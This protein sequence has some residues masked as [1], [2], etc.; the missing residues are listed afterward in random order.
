MQRRQM[1]RQIAEHRVPAQQAPHP[2][3]RLIFWVV[4]DEARVPATLPVGRSRPIEGIAD[5]GKG[6]W[7]QDTFD[8]RDA[9]R[10]Y[11]LQRLVEVTRKRRQFD[12]GGQFGHGGSSSS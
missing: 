9:E 8:P 12:G 11:V 2:L 1:F 3:V 6:R 7:V 4:C 10:P 5:L